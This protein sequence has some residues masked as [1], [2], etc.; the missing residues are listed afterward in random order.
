MATALARL[1]YRRAGRQTHD[2]ADLACVPVSAVLGALR[3]VSDAFP[4]DVHLALQKSFFDLMS[5]MRLAAMTRRLGRRPRAHELSDQVARDLHTR[6]QQHAGEHATFEA[7][8]LAELDGGID[9]F[10][11]D[12]MSMRRVIAA[13]SEGR[14]PL[15]NSDRQSADVVAYVLRALVRTDEFPHDCPSLSV[16]ATCHAAVR[17]GQQ[18]VFRVNDMMDCNHASAALPYC[19][20]FFT[21]SSLRAL[22][23]QRHTK[24]SELFPCAV[25][26]DATTA[27]DWVES[28]PVAA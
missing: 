19:D 24:L 5:R 26:S 22:I 23:H 6:N 28:A 4:A 27:L 9:R 17:W 16:N 13:R 18:R 20:G 8:R 21:E 14:I 2:R 1:L 11:D 12:A 7:P 25:I 15:L 3:P 10:V